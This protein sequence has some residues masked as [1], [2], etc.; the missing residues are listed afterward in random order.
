MKKVLVLLGLL[1]VITSSLFAGGPLYL[2]EKILIDSSTSWS[3]AGLKPLLSND[4]DAGVIHF[5]YLRYESSTREAVYQVESNNGGNSWSTP[6]EISF[7][8]HLNSSRYRAYYPTGDIDDNG[9]IHI[10]YEYRGLPIYHSSWP[11]YPPSHVAYVTDDTSAW[12]TYFDVMNDSAVQTSQGNGSTVSYFFR[13]SILSKGNAQYCIAPDYAWWATKCNIVFSKK[14]AGSGW[15]EGTAISTY[16]RGAIDK[17]TISCAT[18]IS[19]GSNIYAMWFNRYTGQ[20]ITKTLTDTTWG[21]DSVIFT[22]DSPRDGSNSSYLLYPMSGDGK[23]SAVMSR[24]ENYTLN[25]IFLINKDSSGWSVDTTSVPDT[26]STISL[27]AFVSNGTT[28]IFYSNSYAYSK[29][30]VH[31]SDSFSTPTPVQTFNDSFPVRW[32]IGED[33]KIVFLASNLAGNMFYMYSADSILVGVSEATKKSGALSLSNYPNPFARSTVIS[34]QLP[35][36]T[37]KAELKIYDIAGKLV[38][39]FPLI[40]GHSILTTVTWDGRNEKGKTLANGVYF[41]QLKSGED[42][43]TRKLLLL[44]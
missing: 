29:F 44:K 41:Y 20:L 33:N 15:T 17:Y 31:T 23:C 42:K 10:V 35:A 12:A 28:C 38:K 14:E 13:P 34:C 22:A 39:S 16:N 26:V 6:E 7:Y 24:D 40:S 19:D 5:F 4:F 27:N 11:D 37:N 43:I 8:D 21:A 1:G 25:E 32:A 30:L 3:Y 18:L 2:K 36:N 9:N